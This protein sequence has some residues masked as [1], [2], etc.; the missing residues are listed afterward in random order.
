MNYE[1]QIPG[2]QQLVFDQAD[3]PD[4]NLWIL[5]VVAAFLLALAVGGWLLFG[6]GDKTAPPPSPTAALVTVTVPGT[7]EVARAISVTGALAARREMPVGVAGEGG[8]VSQVLVD[9]GAW[10]GAGQVLATIDRSVQTQNIQSLAAQVEVSRADAR[11]AQQNLDRSK[12]LLGKG[13]VSQADIDQKTATRDAAAARVNVAIAQL[14]Q[15]G[16]SA[17]RLNIRAPAAGLVL[18]RSIEPGQVVSSGSGALFRMA[19]GGEMEML[20]RV[21]ESDLAGLK[22]GDAA[23]VTPSGSDHHIVGHIWQISPIIDAQSRQGTVRIQ[24]PSHDPDIRPGGF[25]SASIVAGRNDAPLL[26]ESAVLSDAKGNYVYVIDAANTVERR[27][28]QAGE[29]SDHGVTILSG[30][31]GRE[32]VVVSAGAF[33]TVGQKVKPVRESAR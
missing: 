26:P 12:A 10:V 1:A 20:A 18:T 24:L 19:K 25:A 9:P 4:R 32:Q 29:V 30:L 11:I 3:R 33:L 15:A 5:V 6:R 28:V 23:T 27:P 14:N 16:A 21:A 8:M 7:T 31:T 22:I 2:E 13:F 17:A